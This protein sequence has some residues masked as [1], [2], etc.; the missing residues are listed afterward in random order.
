M[1]DE[2]SVPA[3]VSLSS[4]NWTACY[5][6]HW[7]KLTREG[8]KPTKVQA[9]VLRNVRC[10]PFPR[11]GSYADEIKVSLFEGHTTTTS[12]YANRFMGLMYALYEKGGQFL[13]EDSGKLVTGAQY[14]LFTHLGMFAVA[15]SYGITQTEI[16]YASN[17]SKPSR[18]YQDGNQCR[19]E[20]VQ[21]TN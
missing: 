15:P 1:G 14:M 7:W 19:A 12:P 9:C 10:V 8:E 11:D 6:N 3:T 13:E 4:H 2:P 20:R 21:P 17:N 5:V 18:A 16:S